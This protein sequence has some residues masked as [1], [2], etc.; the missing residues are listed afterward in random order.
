MLTLKRKPYM[1]LATYA[2]S[3]PQS[4]ARLATQLVRWSLFN[5]MVVA[6][7]GVLMRALPFIDGFPLTYKN[8][9]HGHSHFAFGGWVMPVL[10]ALLLKAFPALAQA[11]AFRHWR[12]ISVLLMASAYGMLLAFPLQGYKPVSI[13]FAT[14]SIVAGYYLAWIVW[15]ALR[16]LPVTTGYRFLK[17][18]LLYLTLASLGPFA[19]GPL[20]VLGYHETPLYFNAIYGYL[21]FTYNG[22][23]SFAV[24]AL[25]YQAIER[26]GT[27]RYGTLVYRL[28]HIACVPA[29]ALS[30]LWQQPAVVFNYIGGLAALLQLVA[31]AALLVDA[32]KLVWIKKQARWIMCI[33]LLAFVLKGGL[34][35]ASAFPAVAAMAANGRGFVI[36]YLHLVLLGFVS[37]AALALVVE[38]RILHF[39]TA[40][41]QGLW[42]F[43]GGFVATELL[44]VGA[45][46]HFIAPNFIL[47]L[48]AAAF[49]MLFG[50]AGL[51]SGCLPAAHHKFS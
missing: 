46:L 18:G 51:F 16:Q 41:R 27:S 33:A 4:I 48:L 25:I 7:V 15:R 30:V 39:T 8:V 9:L 34:Q 21:H 32:G 13:F 37:M 19:T 29:F 20:V 38:H 50:L 6:L 24:L 10:L 45:G 23:F 35:L 12:N 44:L 11:V 5:L 40:M 14:L 28:M 49:G 22:F 47:L 1:P 2:G 3:L 36:A 26:E 43:L 31:T 17:A 42:V